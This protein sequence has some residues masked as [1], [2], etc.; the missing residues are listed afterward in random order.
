MND[1]TLYN[2]PHCHAKGVLPM[3]DMRCPNCKQTIDPIHSINNIPPEKSDNWGPRR[4]IKTIATFMLAIALFF[5]LV[6]YSFCVLRIPIE[7][8]IRSS[9]IWKIGLYFCASGWAFVFGFSF[10]SA[11]LII[12]FQVTPKGRF[13]GWAVI[14]F[15]LGI[16]WFVV[17]WWATHFSW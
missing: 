15:L 17:F 7:T 11:L 1:V 6:I 9:K 2:C 5:D 12:C 10:I 14:A 3:A 4:V 13:L 8:I 16:P